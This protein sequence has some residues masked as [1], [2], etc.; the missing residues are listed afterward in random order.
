MWWFNWSQV[1]KTELQNWHSWDNNCTVCPWCFWVCISCSLLVRKVSSQGSHIRVFSSTWLLLV[2]LGK[3]QVMMLSEATQCW[4][5]SWPGMR[6]TG[7]PSTSALSLIVTLPSICRIL[8]TAQVSRWACE[9]SRCISNRFSVSGVLVQE[10]LLLLGKLFVGE[11]SDTF[12][13]GGTTTSGEV[14]RTQFVARI[15][16]LSDEGGEAS[17]QRS[18]ESSL[19]MA[20][21]ISDPYEWKRHKDQLGDCEWVSQ[22]T[23]WR[24]WF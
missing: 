19:A 16:W 7:T 3:S 20:C 5:N 13:L 18:N 24:C 8:A 6:V 1:S 10:I 14:G 22:N 9:V 12:S 23:C 11:T 17:L 4:D 21:R 15:L 2:S